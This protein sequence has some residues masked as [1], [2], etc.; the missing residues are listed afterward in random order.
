LQHSFKTVTAEPVFWQIVESVNAKP[1]VLT[2]KG[3]G[4]AKAKASVPKTPTWQPITIEE[5][6][7][8]FSH[9]SDKVEGTFHQCKERLQWLTHPDRAMWKGKGQ[10]QQQWISTRPAFRSFTTLP[11]NCISSSPASADNRLFPSEM[12]RKRYFSLSSQDSRAARIMSSSLDS[13]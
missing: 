4:K 9:I 13:D 10:Q 6:N 3:K 5:I 12:S 7:G 8:I 11:S 2:G 1:L